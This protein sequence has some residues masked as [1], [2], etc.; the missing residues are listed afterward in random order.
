[1]YIHISQCDNREL[2]Q[3][4]LESTT[5]FHHTENFLCVSVGAQNVATLCSQ[6]VICQI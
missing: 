5:A 4:R 6:A 3:N 1:M 2:S